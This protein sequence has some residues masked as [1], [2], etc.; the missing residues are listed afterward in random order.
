MTAVEV[1]EVLSKIVQQRLRLTGSS[2]VVRHGLSG[3]VHP[4]ICTSTAEEDL[5]NNADGDVPR[6]RAKA[7]ACF[8]QEQKPRS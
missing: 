1:W 8:E 2:A 5:I 3:P 7:V 4:V 6:T